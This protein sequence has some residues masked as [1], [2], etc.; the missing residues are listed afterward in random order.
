MVSPERFD[1]ATRVVRQ[2]DAALP[3]AAVYWQSGGRDYASRGEEVRWEAGLDPGTRTVTLVVGERDPWAAYQ[4][5]RHSALTSGRFCRVDIAASKKTGTVA[6]AR[7]ALHDEN[8]VCLAEDG[9][10]GARA[11]KFTRLPPIC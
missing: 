9:R 5:G 3:T 7:T 10:P 1:S 6:I 8:T 4:P 2:P 11:E